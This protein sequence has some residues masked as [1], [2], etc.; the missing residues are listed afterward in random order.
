MEISWKSRCR[1]SPVISYD[2]CQYKKKL[3]TRLSAGPVIRSMSKFEVDII[4]G[5]FV[6]RHP[7]NNMK[8]MNQWNLVHISYDIFELSFFLCSPPVPKA[9]TKWRFHQFYIIWRW[10]IN[11]ILGCHITHQ[12]VQ[13]RKW[14]QTTQ[15]SVMIFHACLCHDVELVG[16]FDWCLIII[17]GLIAAL[18]NWVCWADPT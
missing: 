14:T 17:V 10:R 18:R 16:S 8:W 6:C 13:F 1:S 11:I 3:L 5:P 4:L 7:R 9:V 15:T 2:V 12:L